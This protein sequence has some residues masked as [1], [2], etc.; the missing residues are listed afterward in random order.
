MADPTKNDSEKLDAALSRLDSKLDSINKRMDAME[1]G[2]ADSKSRADAACSKMD[3]WDEEKKK[4]DAA[5]KDAE[6]EEKK[7]ADA[8]KADAAKKDAEEEEKKKAD[9]AA[10]EDKKKAD[11]AKADAARADAAN[12]D[13]AKELAALKSRMPAAHTDED[14]AKYADVQMRCDSAYQA[15]GAQARGAL[16]GE[17]LS[18]FRVAL[19]NGLK[20]HSK[21][22]KNSNLAILAADDAAFSVIQDSIIQDAIEASNSGVEVGAPLQKRV[23]RM[24][25]GHVVTKWIGDPSVAWAP[26]A[27]GATKFG[28]INVDMANRR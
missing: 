12:A 4:A 9:A 15:W 13:I 5:R 20:K 26:F 19:L 25:S 1:E 23:T 22:Y 27:G 24:D 2:V 17:S 11:A 7:K 28:R 16:Q 3:A 6:D 18:D 21:V 8:A 14:K 10:E